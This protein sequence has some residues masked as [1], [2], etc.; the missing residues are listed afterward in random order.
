MIC[1]SADLDHAHDLMPWPHRGQWIVE[2]P[3]IWRISFTGS[4]AAGRA[5]LREAAPY[6]KNVT[7]ELGGND[8]AIVLPDVDIK[9]V[10]Q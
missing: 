4:T 1:M 3:R 5:I 8:P 10:A 6:V 9:K 7:L 2:H